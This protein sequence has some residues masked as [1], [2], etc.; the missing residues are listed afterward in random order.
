MKKLAALVL[1]V[2]LLLLAFLFHRDTPAAPA[3]YSK[4]T[5][6]QANNMMKDGKPFL[7]LDV[8][9]KEEYDEVHIPGT[10]LIPGDE[11]LRRAPA[12]LPDK[13]ARILV[14]CRSGRRSAAAAEA[15][16]KVGYTNVH[17][18]GGIIDWPFETEGE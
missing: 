16:L 12:E 14:Y 15:L 18:F 4:I 1:L 8:R 17:D 6:V 9:T 10:L 2:L 13:A 3:V 11:L 7:L 5:A